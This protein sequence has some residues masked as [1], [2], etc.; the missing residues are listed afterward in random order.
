VPAAE[1]DPHRALIRAYQAL[2][3]RILRGSAGSGPAP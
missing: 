1:S 3:D 2:V